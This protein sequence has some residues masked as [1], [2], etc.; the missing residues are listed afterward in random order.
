MTREEAEESALD[1]WGAYGHASKGNKGSGPYLDH[2]PEAN[3]AFERWTRDQT[4]PTW[5]QS[6]HMNPTAQR[7]IENNGGYWAA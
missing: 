3:K 2:M 6:S 5:E 7:W 1:R 4:L